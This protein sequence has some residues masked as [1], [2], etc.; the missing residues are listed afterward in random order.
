MSA[1]I[2]YKVKPHKGHYIL[3]IDGKFYCT[4]D[5]ME[6]VEEELKN[7]VKERGVKCEIQSA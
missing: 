6:E 5:N 3:Y 7:Y 4:A 2:T 1:Y